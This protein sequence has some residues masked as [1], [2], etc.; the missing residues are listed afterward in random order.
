VSGPQGAFPWTWHTIFVLR[1]LSGRPRA[2]ARPPSEPRSAK[3]R[4]SFFLLLPLVGIPI[5]VPGIDQISEHISL[6]RFVI[7]SRYSPAIAAKEKLTTRERSVA[8]LSKTRLDPLSSLD[9]SLDEPIPSAIPPAIARAERG[10]SLFRARRVD[11]GIDRSVETAFS[12]RHDTTTRKNIAS[13]MKA[14]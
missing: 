4:V 8:D 3:Y 5:R 14:H 9:S 11:S 7:A 6:E 12:E 2:I 13:S 10:R 1:P